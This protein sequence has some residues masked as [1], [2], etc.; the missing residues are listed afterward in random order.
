MTM[1][2][3]DK[4]SLHL[5]YSPTA[6]YSVGWRH[7]YLRD[8]KANVDSAQVNYLVK[9]W[10]MPKAQA[11]IYVKSGVGIAYDDGEVNPAAFTGL[12]T[13]WENQRFFISYENRFFK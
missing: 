1:N 9:R 12:A 6:D 10:N 13:D 2:D 7:E 8:S 5:H 11:N 4:N 3:V